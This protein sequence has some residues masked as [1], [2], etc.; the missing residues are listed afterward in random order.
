MRLH[1]EDFCQAL[2]FPPYLKYQPD[3]NE[4]DYVRF[5][6][7]LIDATCANPRDARI[8]FGMRLAF[9]FA[10]GNA[11]AHLKNS[12]PRVAVLKRYLGM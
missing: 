5:C 3:S 12:A 1:Q 2:G 4:G 6:S 8:E 9:N 7:H 11:D 10:V